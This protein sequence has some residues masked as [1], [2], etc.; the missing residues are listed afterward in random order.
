MEYPIKHIIL[1]L[2]DLIKTKRNAQKT[3]A[4]KIWTEFLK[5]LKNLTYNDIN[6]ISTNIINVN[7]N[8]TVFESIGTI[9]LIRRSLKKVKRL[10]QFLAT[11]EMQKVTSHPVH[12]VDE[13][14]QLSPTALIPFCSVSN[15][16][17]TM[18]VKI[19]SLDVPVCTAFRPK[20][21]NDQLCY[22][23]DLNDIKTKFYIRDKLFLN[24][25]IDFNEDREFYSKFQKIQDSQNIV[26]IESIG[27]SLFLYQRHQG[28]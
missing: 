18:G 3:S 22:S 9:G 20:Y 5:E 27:K 2:T 24:L 11:P 10:L 6:Q 14:G 26:F 12:I 1:A 8:K 25:L 7:N 15:N 21:F 23:V 13:D 17:S 16:Y 4:L 28:H 19:H